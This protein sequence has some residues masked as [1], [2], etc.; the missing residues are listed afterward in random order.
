[1]TEIPEHLL[2]RSKERKAALS[3]ETPEADATEDTSAAVEPAAAAAPAPAAAPLPD[4]AP[5]PEPE[6]VKV[7]PYVEAYEKRKKMPYWIVPVLLALPVWAA[8]YVGTL[9]RVPQ[10]LSGLLGEGEELYVEDGCS[11]CHGAEGGGGIGRALADGEAHITFTTVEDQ[12]VWVLKGSALVGTGETYSSADST[13][14]RAVAGQMPGYGAGASTELDVEQLLAVV[15]Y[16]RTQ[17]EPV[18]DLAAVDLELAAEMDELI[19]TGAIEE[20]LAEQGLSIHD[21]LAGEDVTADVINRYLE[22]ARAALAGEE[23]EG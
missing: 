22:P 11:G 7:A 12:M 10:G 18:E 3:G 8:F 19:E 4:V 1:V 6:P 9:E 14:P 20:I 13:R 5:D 15:L 2:K 17:F 16:E 21:V 23:E